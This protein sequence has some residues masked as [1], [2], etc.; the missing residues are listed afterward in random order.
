VNS[1][2][3]RVCRFL[4]FDDSG[5]HLRQCGRISGL[6]HPHRRSGLGEE[7]C[8]CSLKIRVRENACDHPHSKNALHRINEAA[9]DGT[10]ERHVQQLI[11]R[12][13]Q[14]NRTERLCQESRQR[15]SYFCG[16]I[17]VVQ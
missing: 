5:Q 1:G 12:R 2:Q 17:P 6:S 10:G 14:W 4:P 13:A 15:G 16:T 9:I 3:S 7:R 11:L 8:T